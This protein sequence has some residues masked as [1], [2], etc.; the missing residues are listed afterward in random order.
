[1]QRSGSNF[2]PSLA[3]QSGDDRRFIRFER[4]P[5]MRPFAPLLAAAVLLAAFPAAGSELWLQQPALSQTQIAFAYAGDLW[6]VPR[7][8]GDARRLTTGL[9]VETDPHFS[10]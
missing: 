3:Y 6:V 9:G 1:M 2:E 4:N 7:E 10:P 8:G 5:G